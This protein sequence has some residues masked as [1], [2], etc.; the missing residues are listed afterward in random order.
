[1]LEKI[2]YYIV[3]GEYE[4]KFV[5]NFRRFKGIPLKGFIEPDNDTILINKQLN[6]QEKIITIIH[7]FIHEIEPRW[8]EEKVE[9]QANKIFLTL[10]KNDLDFF[11]NL[12]R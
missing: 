11:N 7:E 12:I 3:N 9:R 8:S 10:E 6:S 5:N 1:M 2:K 4:I